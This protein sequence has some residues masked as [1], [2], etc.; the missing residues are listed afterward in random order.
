MKVLVTGGAGC[1]GSV[2]A[3]RLL[4]EGN[5]VIVLDDFSFGKKE[6]VAALEKDRK[7]K[8]I[9]GSILDLEL[10]KKAVEG[11]DV[12]FHLAASSTVKYFPGNPTDQ[13]LKVNV[14][15]TYNVLEAMRLKGI[16]KI[17]FSSTS[18]VYG[19][20]EKYPTPEDAPILPVSLYGASKAAGESLISAFCGMFGMQAWIYRFANVVGG[21]SRKTGGMIVSDFI[22]K[23]KKDSKELEV[24]G[25]GKQKKSYITVDDCVN[26]MLFGFSKAKEK[27]NV[28]NLGNSEQTEVNEIARMV[29][30]EMGLEDVKLKYTGGD[31]G[32]IG[33]VPKMLLSIDKISKLGWKPKVSSTEAV[34]LAIKETLRSVQ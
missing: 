2:L 27:V 13:E 12:V 5:E 15:G 23:L 4:K 34:R 8:L 9:R 28:F 30:A 19:E 24:L 22:E 29:A 21:K 26:G 31:R 20:P 14:T 1:I 17:V 18:T 3:E 16:K 7:F 32:W 25:N 33:D 6:H 11:C 10:L